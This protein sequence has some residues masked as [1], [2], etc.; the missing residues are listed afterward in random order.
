MEINFSVVIPL[1]NKKDFIGRAIMSVLKQSYQSFE[2]II[3]NDGSTDGSEN[4][5]KSID[6][7]RIKIIHQENS[8][9]SSA[10]N[11]GV[12]EARSK[13]IAFLDADDEW[14][15][16]TLL[17]FS[18]LINNFPDHIL[19]AQSYKI[20]NEK[21][22]TPPSLASIPYGWM[23]TLD[24]YLE[25]AR[26]SQPFCTSSVCIKKDALIKSGGFPENVKIGEDLSLWLSLDFMGKFAFSNTYNCVYHLDSQNNLSKSYI[27]EF[28]YFKNQLEAHLLKFEKHS[29]QYRNLYEYYV[30]I[31]LTICRNQL[32]LS[33]KKE[34]RSNL[35]KARNTHFLKKRWWK[36]YFLSYLPTELIQKSF[37]LL[38]PTKYSL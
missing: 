25:L 28:D 37:K 34:C 3:V 23:G 27:S 30:S 11:R 20:F 2:I 12:Q 5:I 15:K 7:P 9:A 16:D 35:R 31:L 33:K 26:I 24:N 6:D 29:D 21:I 32:L 38:R 17:E 1:Y 19:F 18:E 10:R 36:I 13:Y 4:E 14:Q 8:G 22:I